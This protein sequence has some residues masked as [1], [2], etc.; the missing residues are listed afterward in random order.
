MSLA[1]LGII[2]A[3]LGFGWPLLRRVIQ[4]HDTVHG[5][6]GTPGIEQRLWELHACVDRRFE[7]MRRENERASQENEQAH[8]AIIEK[9]SGGKEA[10]DAR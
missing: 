7:A 1:E 3:L 5:K 4:I 10:A 9:L 8:R 6:D 2:A